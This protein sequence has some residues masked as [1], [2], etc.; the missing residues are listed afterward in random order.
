MILNAAVQYAA[1]V[2]QELQG[3]TE[4]VPAFEI[5]KR[6]EL[7]STFT[8]QVCRRLKQAEIIEAR[9]GPGGGYVL[10]RTDVDFLELVELF[11]TAYVKETRP[12]AQELTDR[13]NEALRNI[14][15]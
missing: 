4:P 1:I 11:V 10:K 14:I 9:R 15:I 8:D 6:H 12:A 13:V 2:I 7:S 5:V 3:K